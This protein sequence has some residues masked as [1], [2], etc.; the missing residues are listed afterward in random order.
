VVRAAARFQI[1]LRTVAD[2]LRLAYFES[3]RRE[4]LSHGE[5]GRRLGQSERH[6]RS[7]EQRLRGDFFAAEH[8]IGLAREIEDY[9]AT[10]GP[11]EVELRKRFGPAGEHEVNE[12]IDMLLAEG[13]IIRSEASRLRTGR[14][15]VLLASDRF[16]QRIDAL[17]HFLDG[18]YQAIVQRL[19]HDERY[20]AMIKT[21]SFSGLPEQVHALRG[22]LEA[23]LRE[24]ITEI[25][26]QASP[27]HGVRRYAIAV[28][29]AGVNDDDSSTVKTASEGE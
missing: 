7:F 13:R 21:I 9:V 2:L 23:Q 12:A 5:I 24:Q 1:P 22:R 28:A 25:E 4:G 15:Y 10:H 27:Q 19:V 11:R 20:D 26:N 18:A 17:N 16:Q 6:M 29:L 3:L 8:S 14:R